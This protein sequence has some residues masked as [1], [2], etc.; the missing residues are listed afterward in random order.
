[1]NLIFSIGVGLIVLL[2]VLYFV[3]KRFEEM[4]C[5]EVCAIYCNTIACLD[6]LCRIN[7]SIMESWRKFY[8]KNYILKQR[9]YNAEKMMLEE[10]FFRQKE[11]EQTNNNNV[12][13]TYQSSIIKSIFL[14]K[15]K[16]STQEIQAATALV[17]TTEKELEENI[18]YLVELL[19]SENKVSSNWLF[20]ENRM[21][22]FQHEANALY[23]GTLEGLCSF[24]TKSLVIYEQ[25][26][27]RLKFL[28]ADIR[29]NK[30]KE[31][32]LH[33]QEIEFKKAE[34]LLQNVHEQ[35]DEDA[36]KVDI[37]GERLF[38]QQINVF[39]AGSTSLQTERDIYSNVIGQLQTKWKDNNIH[40]YGYSFQNFEHEFVIDGQQCSY[41]DFIKRYTDI[42]IFVLNGN[43][44]GKTKVEFNIAMNS[45]KEH[46]RPL[47]YVY[48]RMS[49]APNEDVES[50]R[51]RINEESQYWQ[52]YPNNDQLR[53]M[54]TNDLTDRL[55]KVYE[56]M[57][58]KQREI[59]N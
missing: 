50:T 4:V 27:T 36:E 9:S 22:Y 5:S 7:N 15:H 54:M 46:R 19:N 39:F 48:S 55:Q 26:R 21:K 12:Q 18:G 35:M 25:L 31:D 30:R 11:I 44:G 23:Y 29:M 32:Y 40:L 43:V 2:T 47:I 56:S 45:F 33:L 10:L 51:K 6:Q 38:S 24:P 13:L 34:E 53:L 1:M 41:N 3:F 17:T 37:M 42:I 52:E 59:L 20:A 8:I 16:L 57:V 14:H 28:P 49:D 58:K